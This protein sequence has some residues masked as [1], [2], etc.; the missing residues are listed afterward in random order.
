MNPN[1]KAVI[2]DIDGVLVGSKKGYNWPNP[3]PEVISALYQLHQQGKTISFCTGKA[4]FAI[5]QMVIDSGIDNIH[6]ADGG[7][8]VYNY[9]SNKIIDKHIINQNIVKRIINDLKKNKIYIELYT[10]DDYYVEE[11]SVNKITYIQHAQILYR[12]PVIVKNFDE[13][14]NKIE[15]TKIMPVARDLDQKQEIIKLIEPYIEFIGLQWGTHP[16]A[17]P[18]QFGVISTKGISKRQAVEMISKTNHIPLTNF[19]GIGDGMTDWGFM[20]ICGYAGAMGNAT[21]E[22]KDK[23]LTKRDNGYIGPSVDENGVVDILKHFKII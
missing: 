1:I 9:I 22:L 3:N 16:T 23:V 12:K 17:L 20:E 14:I 7:A 6:I 11:L 5:K 19:L 18:H 15:V 2:L 21:Q 10:I 13:I 4:S 8:V